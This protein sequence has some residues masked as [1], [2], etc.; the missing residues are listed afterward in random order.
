MGRPPITHLRC[1]SCRDYKHRREFVA[2]GPAGAVKDTVCHPCRNKLKRTAPSQLLLKRVNKGLLS[3]ETYDQIREKRNAERKE[4]IGK[5]IERSLEDKMAATWSNVPRSLGI[6]RYVLKKHEWDT[7]EKL[8]WRDEMRALVN[9][10]A[11]EYRRRRRKEV[12][13]Y[14]GRAPWYAP[15][16]NAIIRLKA[17]IN[18]Y[19]DGA[20]KAPVQVL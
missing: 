20:E 4:G 17:L 16:P 15:L 2:R 7:D 10:A 9:E 1:A 3:L 12:C 5:G 18:K 19:P 14:L 13:P 11:D 6:T 8:A